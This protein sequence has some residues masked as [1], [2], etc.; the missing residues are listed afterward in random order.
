MPI[1]SFNYSVTEESIC[2]AL[3]Q[4][5]VSLSWLMTPGGVLIAIHI[6]SSVTEYLNYS[7]GIIIYCRWNFSKKFNQWSKF[8]FITSRWACHI[9]ILDRYCH[10]FFLHWNVDVK[11]KDFHEY[12]S[13]NKNI[14][15]TLCTCNFV[16]LYFSIRTIN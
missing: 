1:E 7:I 11:H 5:I 12:L 15:V 9:I 14:E 2:I 13:C 10:I 16:F 3:K 4:N 8:S 6:L